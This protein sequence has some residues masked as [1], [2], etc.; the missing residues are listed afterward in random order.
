M[1]NEEALA[2]VRKDLAYNVPLNLRMIGNIFG[3]E[4]WELM[5][6]VQAN[7]TV[8]HKNKKIEIHIYTK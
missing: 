6:L 2:Q 1:I 5:I 3:Q 7:I 8:D 4:F